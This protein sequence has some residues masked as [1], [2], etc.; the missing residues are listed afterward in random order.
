MKSW[1]SVGGYPNLDRA[2][3]LQIADYV[4]DRIEGWPGFVQ[5]SP[6]SDLSGCLRLRIVGNRTT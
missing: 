6:E 3:A 5:K 2:L 4:R 1:A